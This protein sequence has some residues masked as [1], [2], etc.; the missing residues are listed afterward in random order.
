M[1]KKSIGPKI[2]EFR[3]SRNLTQNQ[4]AESLGYS[5]KSVISHIEKGDVDM[6]Y[7]KIL[8]LLRTYSVD[9]NDLFEVKHID[10]LLDEYQKGKKERDIISCQIN[11]TKFSYHLSGILIKGGEI[12]LSKIGNTYILPSGLACLNE[13]SEKAIVRIFKEE[14]DLEVTPHKLALIYEDIYK[15]RNVKYHQLNNVYILKT[16]QNNQAKIRNNN[17]VWIDLNK[18][19]EIKIKPTILKTFIVRNLLK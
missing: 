4:L 15:K 10:D 6:T 7:E 16:K 8:L 1:N 5:G 2:K 14:I 13:K 9:A 12:L 3:E 19:K 18:I 11:E 17:F